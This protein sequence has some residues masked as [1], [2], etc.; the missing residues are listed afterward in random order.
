MSDNE[1][2]REAFERIFRTN[3]GE[4]ISLAE[5][6]LISTTPNAIVADLRKRG[7]TIRNRTRTSRLNHKT[8]ILSWYRYLPPGLEVND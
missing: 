8:V 6:T 7:M 2:V 3:P 1:G 5:L 4:W